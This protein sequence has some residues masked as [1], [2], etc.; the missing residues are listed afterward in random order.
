MIADESCVCDPTGKLCLK[1]FDLLLGLL[2][3]WSTNMVF[4]TRVEDVE[5]GGGQD[6][7]ASK[8]QFVDPRSSMWR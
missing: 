6:A 2:I 8:R 7:R 4:A 1:D 5:R 3:S